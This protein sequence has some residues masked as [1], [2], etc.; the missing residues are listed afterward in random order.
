MTEL[1]ALDCE[2]W[3]VRP[4]RSA[5]RLVCVSSK[6]DHESPI[7]SHREDREQWLQEF[8]EGLDLALSEKALFVNQN[9]AFDFRVLLT[10]LRTWVLAGELSPETFQ[11]YCERVWQLYA[12]DRVR[13]PMISA[14]LVSIALGEPQSVGARKAA[15]L[16]TFSLGSL[17]RR[18]LGEEI[19]G[20]EGDDAWRLRYNELDQVPIKLWPRAAHD[21]AIDDPGW[22][23]RVYQAIREYMGGTRPPGELRALRASWTLGLMGAWGV[24]TDG[25]YVAALQHHLEQ[26]VRTGETRIRQA[27]GFNNWLRPDGSRDM[28]KLRARIA[29]VLPPGE[30]E[31]RRTLKGDLKTDRETLRECVGAQDLKA[32]IDIGEAKTEL[33]TFVPRLLEGT[34]LPIHPYWWPLVE[35]GRL[36]CRDPNLTNV[37]TRLIKVPGL[38]GKV[39]VRSCYIPRPG[40]VYSA[41]DY[42]NAELRAF[43]QIC[44]W[45]FGASKMADVFHERARTGGPDLHDRLAADIL[46][47]DLD[48][49]MAL[50]AAEDESFEEARDVAKRCNFGRLGG[51]GNAQFVKTAAKDEVDLT[52]GGKLG[53]DPEAVAEQLKI[54]QFTLYPEIPAYHRR[55]GE[56][57][58]QA[59]GHRMTVTSCRGG[60]VRGN[61]GFT[62]ACNHFFQNLVSQWA[63]DSAFAI[64]RECYLVESTPLYGSRQVILPHDETILEV[65][66]YKAAEAAE[67]QAEIMRA[68]GQASCPDVPN[69]VEAALMMRWDK[70]AKPVRDADGRLVPWAAES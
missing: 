5:P 61:V 48:T 19:G 43:A 24:R 10:Q 44:L 60:L 57:L 23:I 47:V 46:G 18:Y 62:H 29:G 1:F 30:A 22:A 53:D 31:Q 55:V 66:T 42:S 51:M 6:W 4:G 27:P 34:S 2:T 32:W 21:Y 8:E 17:A 15:K 25:H 26:V 28:S 52:L 65:P 13:D 70:R 67:R 7:L 63:K 3:L 58:R 40:F 16:G 9:V 38:T 68:I 11:S 35:S 12:N 50:K 37:P 59:G 33:Q 64:A 14:I 41:A 36:S 45:W 39:G 49:A 54:R 69:E 56:M 20:K